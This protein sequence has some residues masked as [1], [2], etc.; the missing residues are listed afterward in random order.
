MKNAPWW[1]A[2]SGV[3]SDMMSRDTVSRFFWPCIMPENLARLVF[4][5]SCSLFFW[6]VSFRLPIIWLMLSLSCG[7]LA[8]RFDVDGS[9]QIAL[10]HGGGDVG[11]R[12]HLGGQVAG[13]LIHVVGQLPPGAG[14]ARHLGL[15][16][17]LAFDTDFAS[18]RGDLVGEGTQ[19]VGH[20]VDGVGQRGDLALGFDDELLRQVAVGDRG[21][22]LDDAAHLSGEVRGH[23]VTLSVRSFQVPATP[24]T[25]A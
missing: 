13:E 16:A 6:V 3:S 25:L 10:G 12:A 7:D 1:A 21:H 22:D 17:E 14:G 8:L 19:R 15:A 23:E 18:H 4:S 9:G 24:G 20:A 5:Q 2:T 11:D